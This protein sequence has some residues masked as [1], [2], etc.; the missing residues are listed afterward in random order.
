MKPFFAKIPALLAL[1]AACAVPGAAGGAK[2]IVLAWGD[3]VHAWG[4]HENALM[5]EIIADALESALQG[6]AEVEITKLEKGSGL[7]ALRGADAAV[8]VCEGG[9]HHPLEGAEAELEKLSG[10]GTAMAFFHYAL[11]AQSGEL[12]RLIKKCAGG[13]FERGWSVNPFWKA[14]FEVSAGHP[15]SRGA[16]PFEIRDEWHFNMR[17]D[18]SA[19]IF[20]ILTA[21]PPDEA[22]LR[23]FGPHSGNARVRADMGRAETILWLSE[24]PGGR[25]GMGFTGGHSPWI[26]MNGDCRKLILNSIAWLAKI[27]VPEGGLQSPEPDFDDAASRIAKPERPDREEYLKSWKKAAESWATKR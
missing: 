5:C 16:K 20:P 19:K 22:R 7:G 11:E 15:A 13:A 18:P 25:R 3:S 2:K 8:F 17:F 23:P 21:V 27:D 6:E 12:E 26:L 4:E 10:S 9:P 14:D 1:A 24:G